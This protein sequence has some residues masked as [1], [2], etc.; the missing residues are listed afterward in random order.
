M[1]NISKTVINSIL[2]HSEDDY[3]NRLKVSKDGRENTERH[4]YNIPLSSDFVEAEDTSEI[5]DA[6]SETSNY[7]YDVTYDYEPEEEK[8]VAE[9]T[10]DSIINQAFMNYDNENVIGKLKDNSI[11]EILDKKV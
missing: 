7:D 8:N 6:P 10:T 5:I 1:N 9:D 2:D 11:E 3:A 4:C